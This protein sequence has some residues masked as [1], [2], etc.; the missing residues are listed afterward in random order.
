[1]YRILL[2]STALVSLA[3]IASA[4]ITWSG[5]VELGYNSEEQVE[6]GEGVIATAEVT[7]NLSVDLDYGLTA[8]AEA[9]FVLLDQA[10]GG[11][12]DTDAL[13]FEAESYILRLSGEAYSMAFGTVDFAPDSMWK[14]AGD[15]EAD[16]FSEADGEA[17]VLFNG[18]YGPLTFALSSVL[19]T[20]DFAAGNDGTGEFDQLGLAVNGEFD[21]FDV[22]FAYQEEAGYAYNNENGDFETDQ[23]F[24]LSVGTSFEGIS[25][26]LGYARNETD[27]EDSTGIELG[28]DIQDFALGGYFVSESEGDDNWGVS[29][30]YES[31]PL[32][33]EAYYEDEQGSY[34]TGIEGSYEVSDRVVILAGIIDDEDPE[35]DG[36]AYVGAEFD[37]G[38]GA[39]FLVSYAEA[40]NES[41]DELGAP[42]FR[43]GA[44]ALL[45]LEF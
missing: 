5:Q 36:G 20:D 13:D 43:H 27:E 14:S 38:N 39:S 41:E 7:P 37:L 18:S 25:A 2:A 44:T 10:G 23:I 16:G 29:V 1:M 33:A 11:G 26:R 15:M 34:L 32:A 9:T 42:E 8:E 22:S 31:G 4:E 6:D 3:G 40:D 21:M 17:G 35:D 30:G 45:T 28:Y 12:V 19:H 24:A